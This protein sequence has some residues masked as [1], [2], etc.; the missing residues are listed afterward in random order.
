MIKKLCLSIF[1][2]LTLATV[3]VSVP[4]YAQDAQ[5]A[6]ACRGAGGVWTGTECQFFG[7]ERG[8]PEIIRS[9]ANILIFIIGALAVLMIII[10]GLRYVISAGDSNATAGAKNTILFAVVGLVVAVAAYAIVNFVLT[11]L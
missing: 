7:Q 10:G 1:T 9:V 3:G 11:Q 4:A 2:A 6:E 5:K 8:V